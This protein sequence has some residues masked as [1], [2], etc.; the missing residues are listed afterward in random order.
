MKKKIFELRNNNFDI[1]EN[2]NDFVLYNIVAINQKE[3]DITDKQI[4]TEIIELV[5][6]KNKFE[7]NKDLLDKIRNN[8]FSDNDFLQMG[9]NQIKTTKLNS[10]KDNKKFEINVV[11]LLYSLPVNTFT[12][13]N[14]ESNNIYLVKIKKFQNETI[15]NDQLE[16]Y[17]NK[18]NSNIK[19]TMLK[20]YDLFLNDKYDVEINQKTI[21]RVKNYFQ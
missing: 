7:Y 19:N 6:Q 8:E 17:I 14:D 9:K 16:Q 4:K 20:S 10:I 3:P 5:N 18:Q 15:D 21:E 1:F 12:L 2:E 11:E 13:V